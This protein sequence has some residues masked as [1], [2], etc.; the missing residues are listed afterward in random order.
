M[1]ARPLSGG[2]DEGD[3]PGFGPETGGYA[4]RVREGPEVWSRDREPVPHS[5]RR[6]WI[7]RIPGGSD[8]L[9]QVPGSGGDRSGESERLLPVSAAATRGGRRCAGAEA[10][11]RI[12]GGDAARGSA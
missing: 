4:E 10:G 3:G 6:S 2:R 9:P 5:H 12:A 11:V 8:T 1:L 7:R